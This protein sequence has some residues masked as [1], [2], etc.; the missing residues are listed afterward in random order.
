MLLTVETR[1]VVQDI[2]QNARIQSWFI[3]DLFRCFVR[4]SMIAKLRLGS[5]GDKQTS[6]GLFICF[7]QNRTFSKAHAPQLFSSALF[8]PT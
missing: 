6:K 8:S 7:V 3:T 1:K 2:L 5:T 4:L